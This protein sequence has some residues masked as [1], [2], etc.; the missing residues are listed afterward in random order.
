MMDN[1]TQMINVILGK[2]SETKSANLKALF[3]DL[4]S[5]DYTEKK[6]DLIFTQMVLHHVRNIDN[7][8]NRF[9]NLLNPGG[10]LAIADLYKEDGS[11]HGDDFHGHNGFDIAEFTD[12]LA[13]VGVK[14]LSHGECFVINRKISETETRQFSVFLLIAYKIV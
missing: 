1:S 8:L 11:F 7:I 2:I 12:K 3:F 13:K 6:F 4:E 14:T 9:S 5:S 10:Y